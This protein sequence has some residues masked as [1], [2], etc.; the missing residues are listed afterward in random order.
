[1]SES[2]SLKSFRNFT[3]SL[4]KAFCTSLFGFLITPIIILNVGDEAYG[5]YKLM[6]DWL[7]NVWM[8][9]LGVSGAFLAVSAIYYKKNITDVYADGFR[10]HLKVLPILIASSVI[11]YFIILNLVELKD[12]S[13]AT[14][15]LS[16]LILAL[17]F[18]FY[19][20]NIFRQYFE[21]SERS[22]LINWITIAQLF[23]TNLLL[24]IM[25]KLGMGLIG[26]CAAYS[27]FVILGYL[28]IYYFFYR[29]Q[30]IGF[31]ALLKGSGK[32]TSEIKKTGKSYLSINISQKISF[33]ADNSI[34]AYFYSPAQVVLF[35][36]SQRLAGLFQTQIQ[37]LSF[38]AWASLIDFYNNDERG[39]FRDKF[40][41]VLKLNFLIASLAFVLCVVYNESFIRLWIGSKY[42]IDN[43]FNLI[44]SSLLVVNTLNFFIG[45]IITGTGLVKTQSRAYIVLG[46]ANLILSIVFAY[47]LGFH[48]PVLA[49]LLTMGFLLIFKVRLIY[50]YYQ[51][52]ALSLFLIFLRQL[53]VVTIILLTSLWVLNQ[54]YFE[55]GWTSLGLY[56]SLSSFCFMLVSYFLVFNSRERDIWFARIKRISNNYLGKFK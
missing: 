9:D 52:S 8:F 17:T 32:Y 5:L 34:I 13:L 41:E 3:T 33:L 53:F 55:D 27:L 24:L 10:L 43:S 48:G 12:V 39:H 16:F 46:V 1:M 25:A 11:F 56:V 36:I 23:C 19:P 54:S 35:F 51:V 18:L 40:I 49:S 47:Y 4:F 21:V 31:V 28:V 22:S 29:E 44:V 6:F 30:K 38:S 7:S 2:K 42:Y 50:K 20:L 45:H 14:Y 37:G 15:S 26:I